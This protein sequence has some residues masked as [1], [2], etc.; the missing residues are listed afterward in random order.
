MENVDS[1]LVE[2]TIRQMKIFP[3]RR[4]FQNSDVVIL[5]QY[6]ISSVYILKD[7]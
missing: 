5:M 7:I 2:D 3:T 4:I 1:V 6:F